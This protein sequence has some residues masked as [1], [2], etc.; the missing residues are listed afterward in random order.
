METDNFNESRRYLKRVLE[1]EPTN[2]SALNELFKL[3]EK[4]KHT[5]EKEKQLY[6]DIFS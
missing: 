2:K 1:L 3:N 6:K 4:V 5:K